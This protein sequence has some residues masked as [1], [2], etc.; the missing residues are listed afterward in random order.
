MFK[1]IRSNKPK[2]WQI[3]D[4]NSE[5]QLEKWSDRQINV[6]LQEIGVAES[7][8]DVRI[9]TEIAVSAYAYLT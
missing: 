6:L 3:F 7:N 9:L 8:D 4:I 2:I 5:K 1:V